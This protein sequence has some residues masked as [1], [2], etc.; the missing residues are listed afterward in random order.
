MSR[1]AWLK[2]AGGIFLIAL[3]VKIFLSKPTMVSADI[4][5]GLASDYLST[6]ALTLT[7][8]IT[9]ISFAAVFVGFGLRASGNNISPAAFALGIF[10]GSLAWWLIL[11]GIVEISRSRLDTG[12]MA[13]VNRIS[14]VVIT[15][16]GILALSTVI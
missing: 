15:A 14:G 13:W 7:N 6:L 4:R 8:P 12:A 9:I 1:I 5:R 3:G 16:F 10:C 2:L 11:C